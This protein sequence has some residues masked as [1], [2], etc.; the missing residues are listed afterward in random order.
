MEITMTRLIATTLFFVGFAGITVPLAIAQMQDAPATGGA[1][2]NSSQR[3]HHEQRAFSM[4]GERV[5]AK[6]AY[7]KTALKITPAQQ[8]QWDAF[9]N[10][11]RKQARAQ[12]QRIQ[13]WRTQRTDQPAE[14]QRPTAIERLERKQKLYTAALENLQQRL[15]AAKPLYAVLTPE[16]QQVA[17]EVLASHDGRG[18]LGHHGMHR[19]A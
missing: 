2:W 14:Q 12:D 4:P 17:D 6:L 9:A 10:T 18:K 3:A 11:L 5:E 8:P 13:E 7:L 16:Q 19:Q 15:A 1:Q